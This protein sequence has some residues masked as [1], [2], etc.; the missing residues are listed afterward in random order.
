MTE[1]CMTRL[2]QK[3]PAEIPR[4]YGNPCAFT[5]KWGDIPNMVDAVFDADHK[6]P[7][8]VLT[9]STGEWSI[10]DLTNLRSRNSH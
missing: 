7:G 4:A 2:T 10:S 3:M 5:I 6:M 9:F 8:W 1:K